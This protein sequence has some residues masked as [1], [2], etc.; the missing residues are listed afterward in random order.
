M[1][2]GFGKPITCCYGSCKDNDEDKEM[3]FKEKL[4]QKAN[5]HIIK[6]DLSEQI[7][8]IKTR[9]DKHFLKREFTISLIKMKQCRSLAIGCNKDIPRFDDLIPSGIEPNYYCEEY[10]KELEKLGF[11]DIDEAVKNYDSHKSYELIL[12]W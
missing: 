9:L 2:H 1:W 12:R 8:E 10:I 5:S 4:T 7:E 11:T 3:T 6:I